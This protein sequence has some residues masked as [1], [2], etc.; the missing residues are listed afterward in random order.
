MENKQKLMAKM[1][2][3]QTN[4][5]MTQEQAKKV[6]MEAWGYKRPKQKLS[7]EDLRNLKQLEQRAL[8]LLTLLAK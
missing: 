1:R 5:S 6:A 2:N 4:R 7:E 8:N 3:N